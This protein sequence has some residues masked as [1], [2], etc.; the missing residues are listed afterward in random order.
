M[1]QCH[2]VQVHRRSFLLSPTLA[3]TPRD[4]SEMLH[5][6]PA[7]TYPHH[8][9]QIVSHNVGLPPAQLQVLVS[10][11]AAAVEGSVAAQPLDVHDELLVDV[12]CNRAGTDMGR[13][14]LGH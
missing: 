11:V 4:P 9:I 7:R 10:A 3:P 5:A 13:G 8:R 6:A 12:L 1:R 2:L 14:S